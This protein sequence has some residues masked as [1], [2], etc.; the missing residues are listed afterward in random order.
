ML[1]M[2]YLVQP[3]KLSA[4]YLIECIDQDILRTAFHGGI[5]V[6]RGLNGSFQK[7]KAKPLVV[8]HQESDTYV[9]TWETVP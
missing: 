9:A 7:L 2:K 8:N 6:Y 1:L 5:A 3:P 4:A